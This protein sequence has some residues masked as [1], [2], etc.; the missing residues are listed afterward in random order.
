MR[1]ALTGNGVVSWGAMRSRAQVIAVHPAMTQT[2][3][4]QELAALYADVGRDVH[5]VQAKSESSAMAACIGASATGTRAFT[6]TS[7]QSLA[8][9]HQ[10]LHQAAL[11]R[12]PMVMAIARG[13]SQRTERSD[14]LAQRDTG[15]LQFY[16]Q[17]SQ[18]GLDTI[19]QAFR[20]CEQVSL[21]GMLILD[22][23]VFSAVAEPV[24]IPDQKKA[25]RY[26]PSFRPEHKLDV[27]TPHCFGPPISSQEYGQ[28]RRQM[29]LAMAKTLQVVR[30][31][32]QDYRKFFGRG[33][34]LVENYRCRGAETI[35]VVSGPVANAAR[36][37]V[38]R[39]RAQGDRVGLVRV[40]LFRPFPAQLIR[41]VLKGAKKVAV[42]EADVSPGGE[43]IFH[44]EI[45][46][47]LYSLKPRL[48]APLFGFIVELSE[49][50]TTSEGIFQVFHRTQKRSQPEEDIIWIGAK[51]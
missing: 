16:C 20:I 18:E 9:M 12:L 37:V 24:D 2:S 25:D 44:Q 46:S 42:V 15:W 1:R 30:K 7:T 11:E 45:K 17:S 47:A 48:K 29:H 50:D 40:R 10:M 21:P 51:G 28:L 41:D 27:K 14:P 49:G 3:L 23:D 19:V 39:L 8:A 5:F 6:A 32:D 26:L 31:A 13:W 33:H 22:H 34:G 4:A 35:L 43:G 38:D 36:E